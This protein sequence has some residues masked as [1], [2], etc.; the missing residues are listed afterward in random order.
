MNLKSFK[1][2]F[3]KL[4][5]KFSK[6]LSS[7][8]VVLKT[9]KSKKCIYT[10]IFLF[11]FMLDNITYLLLFGIKKYSLGNIMIRSIIEKH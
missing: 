1:I 7:L 2:L 8:H 11:V 5:T 4:K 6:K 10:S 3:D 9:R